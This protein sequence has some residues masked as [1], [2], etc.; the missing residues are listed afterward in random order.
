MTFAYMSTDAP[1]AFPSSTP[2]APVVHL[3]TSK[4]KFKLLQVPSMGE[5]RAAI[6]EY[7]LARGEVLW[8]EM[9]AVEGT[10]CKLFARRG[11]TLGHV[12]MDAVRMSLGPELTARALRQQLTEHE[13]RDALARVKPTGLAS[14]D[15]LYRLK[16]GTE[17]AI[18]YEQLMSMAAASASP[19][20]FYDALISA[21]FSN[22]AQSNV[23]TGS[24]R[25]SFFQ[26]RAYEFLGF[27][28]T[29]GWLLFP[30]VHSQSG[31]EEHAHLQ[32]RDNAAN[33]FHEAYRPS[34]AQLLLQEVGAMEVAKTTEIGR[35]RQIR[36]LMLASS[37]RSLEQ[38][39]TP[40][41]QA[42]VDLVLEADEHMTSQAASQLRNTLNGVLRLHNARCL[43]AP[44]Q[45]VLFAKRQAPT[46]NDYASFA[47]LRDKNPRLK[48]WS[49][50]FESF[51]KSTEDTQGGIKKTACTHFGEF[52]CSLSSPP[53][54]PLEATRALINDY[55]AGNRACY[56][57]YLAATLAASADTK[58]RRLQLMAQFFDFV[59]QRLLAAHKGDPRDAPWLAQPVDLKLDRFNEPPKSGTTRKAIAAH[60]MEEMRLVL[61]EDDYAWSRTQGG[62]THLVNEE[63]RALEYVWC[64]SAA[65]MLY[66]LLSVPLR[67]LQSRLLDSGEGDALIFDFDRLTMVRNPRQLA[68]D[69]VIDGSRQE[70]VLQVMPSGMLDVVD[71]VGVWVPVNKTSDTGYSIPWVSDDLLRHLRYQ[72][73][74]VRQYAA[75][76]NAHGIDDAQGRRNVPEEWSLNKKKFFCL[77]RDPSVGGQIDPSLPVSRQKLLQLWTELC[78]ETERRINSR[79]LSDSQRIKLVDVSNNGKVRAL[80]DIHTLRVSG[81]TDLLDRGVPLNIVSEYVAGH[82]TYIMTLWYDRP[83]P[84]QMRDVLRTA[85]ARAGHS[86]APIPKFT[87]REV[88]EMR[89]FLVA[90]PA[91]DGMYTGFDAVTDNAGL[92]Q[93]RMAGICPGTRCEEGGLTTNGRIAAVPVGDRGPSCPQCRFWLT[94]PAF[95]L[96]QCIEG[97]QLIVK[98]RKKVQSLDSLR[99]SILQAEDGQDFGRADLLRGQ[100]DVEERQL[101]DMLTEWWHR[102]K[103]YEASVKKLD[104][105]RAFLAGT[106]G[107]APGQLMLVADE[108]NADLSFS[109]R[110]ATALE[111]DHFLSTCAELLPD[112]ALEAGAVARDLEMAVGKFLAINSHAELTGLYFTLDD[113]QRLTAANLAVELMLGAAEDPS[114]A[115]DIL[116][117]RTP[118]ASLPHLQKGLADMLLEASKAKKQVLKKTIP[119]KVLN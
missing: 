72:H 13:L 47:E 99:G 75:N 66:T 115:A 46:L 42:C 34:E 57:G 45:A 5:L 28:V 60:V 54:S 65:I 104:D 27:S 2:L 73:E 58:N 4:T 100:A 64:P 81:I 116:E 51:V 12:A 105:Y 50:W 52:L 68:M 103:L 108:G 63:T 74:W 102:M 40:L 38:A 67:S 48:V 94:G 98:I 85:N 118:L 109:F 59:K 77:F 31:I 20:H 26:P 21:V 36:Q 92:L 30:F 117:G 89:P 88:D 43:A 113:G 10:R 111:L 106:S 37:F 6:E 62:W 78:A 97:N 107:E 84:G 9:S 96:G 69:G 3:N 11:N 82:A 35:E 86:A 53:P 22:N 39:T 49:E 61:T 32:H 14:M 70:G 80:H 91:Y 114:K 44:A 23:R 15:D 16:L 19:Y 101:N 110:K 83:L 7:A 33:S 25:K 41:F 55:S 112:Y 95:L 79:A 56:R 93:F 29:K 18:G 17:C 24:L 8:R 71:I 119:L 76:P 1:A 90:N 87:D